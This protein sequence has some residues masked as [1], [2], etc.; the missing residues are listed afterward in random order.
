MGDIN[1]V[2]AEMDKLLK[3]LNSDYVDKGITEV[4][5]NLNDILSRIN[6]QTFLD[7]FNNFYDNVDN[8]VISLDKF[9]NKSKVFIDVDD[10]NWR[11]NEV[12]ILS[13]IL[14][15]LLI[16]V[17]FVMFVFYLIRKNKEYQEKKKIKKIRPLLQ[18]V[19]E[20][21]RL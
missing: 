7:G 13:E 5:I 19:L 20:N 8:L 15:V 12:L 9:S 3:K 18:N 11:L 17:I 16:I 1:D 10:S 4:Y 14:L 6:N 2:L 21:E